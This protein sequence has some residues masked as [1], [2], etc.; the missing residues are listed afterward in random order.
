MILPLCR[1]RREPLVKKEK[2]A[3]RVHLAL[4]AKVEKVAVLE[5]QEVK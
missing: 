1:E 5:H 3:I 4:K 2:W